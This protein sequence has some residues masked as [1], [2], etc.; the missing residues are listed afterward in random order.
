MTS[1]KAEELYYQ[2]EI[3][4]YQAVSVEAISN[5]LRFFISEK[6]IS[7]KTPLGG[8]KSKSS[9]LLQIHEKYREFGGL[10]SN[11]QTSLHS[12]IAYIDS[13]RKKTN[14]PVSDAWSNTSRN[15]SYPISCS[16]M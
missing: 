7:E 3:Q 6:V 8:S 12:L 15:S 1:N 11:N 5:A 13:F 14:S 16:R 2:G 4:F 9:M 10:A